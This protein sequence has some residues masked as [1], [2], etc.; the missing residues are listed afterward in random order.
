V[1]IAALIIG[2]FSILTGPGGILFGIVAIILGILGR[3]KLL[4]E[5]RSAGVAIGGIICGALG[6]LSGVGFTVCLVAC[7]S[8]ANAM[9][10]QA[11]LQGQQWAEQTANSLATDLQNMP[12]VPPGTLTPATPPAAGVATAATAGGAVTLN[13]PMAGLFSTAQPTDATGRPYIDYTFVAA[14]PGTYIFD[15]QSQNT[16]LYDPLIQVM[17]GTNM[18]GSDDDGGDQSLQSRLTQALQPGMYTVRV[19]SFRASQLQAPVP[20]TLTARQ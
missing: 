11:E 4:E 20:F 9:E 17:Q 18:I 12:Q 13:V 19:T 1:G 8:C 15:L 14:A 6:V 10:E 16:T 7:G 3:R 2:I 5:G